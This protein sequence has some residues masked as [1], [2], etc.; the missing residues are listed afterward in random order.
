MFCKGMR[1]RRRSWKVRISPGASRGR[2]P[3]T[4]RCS[5]GFLCDRKA[6][7]P[8]LRLAPLSSRP[9]AGS[10]PTISLV[11]GPWFPPSVGCFS[12]RFWER[13]SSIWTMRN[14]FSRPTTL[15]SQSGNPRSPRRSRATSPLSPSPT[16]S[17]SLPATSSRVSTTGIIASR[18]SRPS[19]SC[20]RAS[21]H[22]KY[23][24]AARRAGGAD[25][26]QPGAG[27]SGAGGAGV[28]G[29]TGRALRTP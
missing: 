11:A 4:N 14:I 2:R 6:R 28:C 24:R 19:A 25:Q 16:T 18:S 26:C 12:L 10:A 3:A 17:M 22:R 23:R 13:A 7:R 29:T 27:R 21:Q 20:R 5:R 9:A 1:L 8:R 15:S